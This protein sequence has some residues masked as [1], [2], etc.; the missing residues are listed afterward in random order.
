M[1]RTLLF[2]ILLFV[3]SS[4]VFASSGMNEEK[5][6]PDSRDNV[7]TLTFQTFCHPYEV[8]GITLQNFYTDSQIEKS[9]RDLGYELIDT[10]EKQESDYTG[11][12]YYTITIKT[13]IKTIGNQTTTVTVYSY[14]NNVSS[15]EILFPNLEKVDK[16]KTTVKGKLQDDRVFYWAHIITYE[17]TKVTIAAAGA[18]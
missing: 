10:K 3:A 17:G 16:F 18:E 15:I 1:K 11:E 14:E 4:M 7:T 6:R 12:E 5:G 9:L 8:E 2:A 13:F